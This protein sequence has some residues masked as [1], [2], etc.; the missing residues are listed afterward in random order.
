MGNLPEGSFHHCNL[1]NLARHQKDEATATEV[2]RIVQ[3][4]LNA[5][6]ITPHKLTYGPNGEVPTRYIGILYS[7]DF[8][9][10]WRYYIAKGPGVPPDVAEEFHKTWGNE[11]RVDG[12][13]GCPSPLEWFKGFAVGHYHIDTQ[14]GLNA[15]AG[16]LQSIYRDPEE[17]PKVVSVSP[18]E[19]KPEKEA[20]RG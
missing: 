14:E 5:A 11:V 1:P 20:A 6:G 19:E 16:L 13:C 10:A 4:E 17:A 18:G 2:D 8:R 7:W 3:A 9:R 15:F 12:H